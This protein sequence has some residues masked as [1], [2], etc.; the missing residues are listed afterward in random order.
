VS[1]SVIQCF[2]LEPAELAREDLRR[3]VSSE[4]PCPL[5]HGY[6]STTVVLGD[7]SFTRT[8]CNGTGKDDVDHNDPRWPSHCACGYAY[9]WDDQ[10]QHNLERLYSGALDGKLYT[11]RDAPVGAMWFA[12]WY[13]DNFKGDDGRCLVVKTPGGD[14]IVDSVASGGGRWTRTGEPPHVTASPSILIHGHGTQAG[15]HGWLRDGQLISC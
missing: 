9:R 3:Y 8:D 13:S 6:H 5:P 4:T 14:W 7:V 10:W 11:L 12:P 2:L 1:G 15:Y